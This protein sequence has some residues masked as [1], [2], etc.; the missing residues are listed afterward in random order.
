V[1]CWHSQ[2]YSKICKTLP[3]SGI[4]HSLFSL[5]AQTAIGVTVAIRS[6]RGRLRC[7]RGRRKGLVKIQNEFERERL[8]PRNIMVWWIR[9]VWLR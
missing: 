1:G 2:R 9:D 4:G 8:F 5:Q 7:W 3:L 6:T